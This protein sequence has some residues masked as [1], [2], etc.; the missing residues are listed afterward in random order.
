MET[1]R[2]TRSGTLRIAQTL[3]VDMDALAVEFG[4]RLKYLAD[5]RGGAK[6]LAAHCGLKPARMY[7]AIGGKH[8]PQLDFLVAIHLGTGVYLPWLLYGYGKPWIEDLI[9][10][11]HKGQVVQVLPARAAEEPEEYKA[12]G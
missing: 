2:W 9:R 11:P 10:Y 12:E 6:V 3:G 1:E 8:W 7:T 5:C 4:Q